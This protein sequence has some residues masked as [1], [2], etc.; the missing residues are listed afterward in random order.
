MTVILLNISSMTS[1]KNT[2][3]NVIYHITYDIYVLGLLISIYPFIK[4]WLNINHILPT[5]G[6]FV[7]LNLFFFF[8]NSSIENSVEL[9][10][11]RSCCD[12][13]G[14]LAGNFRVHPTPANPAPEQPVETL[15]REGE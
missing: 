5:F 4:A 13:Y 3:Q 1:D 9:I 10:D 7:C 14:T 2:I 6:E 8:F 11:M 12:K 15:R